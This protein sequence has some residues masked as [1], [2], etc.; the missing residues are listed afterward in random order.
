MYLEELIIEGFKSYVSRTHIT[1]WDAEFNAITGLNGSGKSNILDAICFVLGITNLSQ[2]RASNL[3]DLIYK[4][5]QAGVTKASVT[6]VFNNENRVNSP[7]GF[8]T[9]RQITVTR[10]VLMGGKTKY[11]LNGHNAQQQTVQNL[12]QSVQLNI[13]NPH[14]L[15]MQGRITKVLNM[16]PTEILSMVEEAAGTKMF[17]DRKNKAFATMGK[18]DRKVEEI[19]SILREE[20]TPRLDQL[21]GEK[22]FYLEYQKVETEMERLSRFVV[23]YEYYRHME[24]LNRF[25]SDNSA[26]Q[27]RLDRLLERT[28]LLKTELETLEEDKQTATERWRTKSTEEGNAIKDLEQLVKDYSNQMVRLKTN[29][30]LQERSSADELAALSTLTSSYNELTQALAEKKTTFDLVKTQYEDFK[31]S[32]DQKSN[33]LQRTSELLQTLTTGITSEEGHENG[34]R[35]QLQASKSAATEAATVEEQAQLNLTHLQKEFDE[36]SLQA[37]KVA[38]Q[39]QGLVQEIASKKRSLEEIE[40]QLNQLNWDPERETDLHHRRTKEQD[41]IHDLLDQEEDISRNLSNLDFNYSDP[42]PNFDRSQVKGMVA[43]LITLDKENYDASTALEI[44]AGGRLYNVVVENE[45][46]GAQLLDH[47]R[48]RR[49]CTLIPLNKIDSFQVSAEKITIAKN[50]GPGQVDLALTLVGYDEQVQ[51]AMEWI[52]G[53]TFIC[54]DAATAKRVTFDDKLRIKS[55]TLDGDIYDP[56]GTLSGGSKPVTSGVLVKV[57]KLNTIRRDLKQHRQQLADLDKEIAEAQRTIGAYQKYKQRLDL[58]THEVHLLE[59]RL[60]KSAH[61]QLVQRLEVIKEETAMHR[62]KVAQAQKDKETALIQAEKIEQEMNDFNRNKQLKLQE[63]TKKVTDLK[64][65]LNHSTKKSKEMQRNV[66]TLE[67]EIEQLEADTV[68]C[69]Q[70]MQKVQQNIDD[71]QQKTLDMSKEMDDL[72]SKTDEAKSKL[73]YEINLM[74]SYNEEIQELEAVIKAKS[75]EMVDVNL[76]VQKIQHD[77]DRFQKDQQGARQTIENLENEHEWIADQKEFFGQENSAYDYRN[78]SISE[79]KK[80]LQQVV[81]KHDTMRKKI[82]V[83]VMNMI[84]NV[85]KKE[86][87]LKKMLET[88]QKDRQKIE[89][90]VVSLENYKLEALENTWRKVNDDFAAIFGDLLAGNTCKLQAPE[91]KTISEGLEVKVCLGGV[92]K[93]SLTE[94]SG[95]QRSLIALSLILSLLQFKPAPMYILDEVDAALDLSHTQNIGQLLRT[96]FKGSQFLVVSLK[97][98]MFNNANVLFKT[99]FKDGTSVVERTTSRIDKHN[100]K[101][102]GADTTSVVGQKRGW[103]KN[104]TSMA[105]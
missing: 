8:E 77:M 105:S 82:N 43:E 69:Q 36:K 86:T 5:G 56:H 88:V 28:N 84:D 6:I 97:D 32:Y 104:T 63:M 4:R 17:E 13:N 47:G 93:Q 103:S 46:V 33:E 25:D 87:S 42:S 57:Q 12:F 68:Q 65:S 54:Q 72:K 11:I 80:M 49:R 90:T 75:S 100:N 9:Y 29:Y 59:T 99:R 39:D 31:L 41:I 71:L 21:R 55:V 85:E 7:L 22:Q 60:A 89:E 79:T 2:V 38:Q 15:I 74:N 16:K 58:Q 26:K 67:L 96:R 78:I 62:T 48:L 101:K 50:L 34:Y 95:G 73:E 24:R 18:K 53:N 27:E 98:G 51:K 83:R 64:S 3:Q 40:Q 44:C 1:G 14:F 37:A 61:S 70:D 102:T 30:S 92:W 76:K 35:E 45:D 10:Q 23:S 81:A 91:G 20:I 19:N 52:F 66:Q 94:L